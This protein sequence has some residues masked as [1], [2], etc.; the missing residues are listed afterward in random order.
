MIFFNNYSLKLKKKKS[1]RN[2][3]SADYW[4]F[5]KKTLETAGGKFEA[6][7]EGTIE[8]DRECGQFY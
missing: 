4:E 3:T 6:K 2:V 8:E 5:K 7:P 1:V